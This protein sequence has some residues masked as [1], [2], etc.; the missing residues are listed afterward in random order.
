[1]STTVA[2][3]V[4]GDTAAE[5]PKCPG[6]RLPGR[7]QVMH[8]ISLRPMPSA[9]PMFLGHALHTAGK[10]FLAVPSA[11]CRFRAHLVRYLSNAPLIGSRRGSEVRHRA[12]RRR[13]RDEPDP[14]G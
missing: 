5:I 14:R 1:V 10:F 12:G 3:H 2:G 8:R 7:P 9:R 13:P 4:N 6:S 11:F